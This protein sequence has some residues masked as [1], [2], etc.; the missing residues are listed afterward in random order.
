MARLNSDRRSFP[1]VVRP[2][3]PGSDDVRRQHGF[4]GVA[5]AIC[6]TLAALAVAH[7]SLSP[8]A[9][10]RTASGDA[11]VRTVLYTEAVREALPGPITS[12]GNAASEVVVPRSAIVLVEG[13]PRVFVEASEGHFVLTPVSLGVVEGTDQRIVSGVSAHE[14]VVAEGAEALRAA[15][16]TSTLR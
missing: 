11:P 15:L 7:R 14:V 4:L 8:N 10:R 12:R 16:I 2:H 3:A 5:I 6:L 13:R 1:P 9:S